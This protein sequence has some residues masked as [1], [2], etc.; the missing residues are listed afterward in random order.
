VGLAA[1]LLLLVRP[2]SLVEPGFQLSFA[3]AVAIAFANREVREMGWHRMLSPPARAILFAVAASFAT[4]LLTS[5]ISATHF[6]RIA[7]AALLGNLIAVPLI[8]LTMPPLFVSLLASPWPA[9]AAWPAAAAVLLLRALHALAGWLSASPWASMEVPAPGT[10][11]V[12]VYLALLALAGLALRGAWH[13][14]RLLLALGLAAAAALAGP[15]VQARWEGGRLRVYVL[16]IGQGDAIAIAT[17]K[18]HWLLVDAGPN[19]N[20]FDAGRRRVLPFLRRHGV[21]RLEAW[22]ISHPDLDHVGGGP[23]VLHAMDVSRVIGPGRVTGQFGQ[24]RVLKEL[25]RDSVRWIR[26]VAGARLTVDAVTL[27]FLHPEPGGVNARGG[28]NDQSVVFLLEYGKFRMLFTGDISAVAEAELLDRHREE[29]RATVLKVAHHGSATSTSASFLKAVAPEL[30][31]ISVG[32]PNRYGHPAPEVLYR[33]AVDS[34]AVRRT[35]QDGT[36][37]V[38]VD[39]T[40]R[41]RVR[42]AADGW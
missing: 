12:G 36:V 33:L 1:T 26:G 28:T 27:R 15:A 18:R 22:L 14:R 42:S 37:F 20:G 35:D 30:A 11:V 2:W 13:R 16:D 8:G 10:T 5:P 38:E 19:V 4:L 39:S 41:W 24:V 32:Q 34:V 23:A 29:I 6:G 25:V 31:V 9:L 17:P 40:G 21:R 7:P 3:G